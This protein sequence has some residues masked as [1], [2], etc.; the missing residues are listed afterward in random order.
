MRPDPLWRRYD[1]L[2]GSDRAAD[3]KDELRF[4]LEPRS[5]NLSAKAG[6]AKTPAKKQNAS[7]EI[8]SPSSM[9]GERIGEHMDRR[10]RFS[11][12]WARRSSRLPL[13][14]PH[15]PPRRW[16]Y[17]CCHSDSHARH[18]RQYCGLRVVNTLLLRPLPFPDSDEL[19][20][21]HRRDP[22][23][24]ETPTSPPTRWRDFHTEYVAS[25][26]SHRLLRLL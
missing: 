21:I 23:A 10:R 2:S 15:P 5:M 26:A 25:S 11:D 3:V 20:R 8:F 4:H 18:R 13:H 7:S 14:P 19:V 12:Y 16:L 24:G 6:V 17:G 1:R 9:L 22:K